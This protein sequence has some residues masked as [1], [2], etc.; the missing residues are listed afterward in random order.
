MCQGKRNY[1]KITASSYSDTQMS[2]EGFCC[3]QRQ[4]SRGMLHITCQQ[5]NRVLQG[6][7]ME[8][9]SRSRKRDVTNKLLILIFHIPEKCLSVNVLMLGV[10]HPAIS[11]P[12]DYC[13]LM[14]SLC[15]QKAVTKAPGQ[16]NFHSFQVS[17]DV[18]LSLCCQGIP[19]LEQMLDTSDFK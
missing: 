11:C 17:L 13:L 1:Y 18:S 8:F 15:P 14:C 5:Y 10:H 2:F 3:L 9:A 6:K 19:D 12:E 16:L 7:A 4:Q